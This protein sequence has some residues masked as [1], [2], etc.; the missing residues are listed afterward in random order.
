M[1]KYGVEY[2]NEK[3]KTGSEGTRCPKCGAEL[4]VY[5]PKHRE[6]GK[7]TEQSSDPGQPW[8]PNCGTEPWE[9]K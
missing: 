6:V 8:C 3:V 1:E 7:S 2:D 5:F 9:K 4:H